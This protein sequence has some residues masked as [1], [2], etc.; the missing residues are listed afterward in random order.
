MSLRYLLPSMLRVLPRL[1]PVLLNASVPASHVLKA[2]V[3]EASEPSY[4]L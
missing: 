1:I 3:L 2:K 4:S